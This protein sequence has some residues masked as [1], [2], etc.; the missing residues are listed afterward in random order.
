[1]GAHGHVVLI[2]PRNQGLV[3]MT[4]DGKQPISASNEPTIQAVIA[5]L[6]N[7]PIGIRTDSLCPSLEFLVEYVYEKA[8]IMFQVPT[9]PSLPGDWAALQD[10]NEAKYAWLQVRHLI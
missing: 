9:C 3:I 10:G 1:M 7:Q 4:G 6:G 5:Y 8:K 2:F